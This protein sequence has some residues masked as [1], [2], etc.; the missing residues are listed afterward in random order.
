MRG[1]FRLKKTADFQKIRR[2]GKSYS[3]PL[4]I[5]I[6]LATSNQK[7][8]IGIAA[9]KSIGNAVARNRAKRLM[10]AAVN[11]LID[12]LKSERDILLL[13]RKDTILNNSQSIRE[14]I[15]EMAKLSGDLDS[16]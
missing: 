11:P 5:Y 16:K 4:V 15:R 12:E 13:A 8:R 1:E 9:G 6:S 10:R 7:V 14:A 2:N 3:H